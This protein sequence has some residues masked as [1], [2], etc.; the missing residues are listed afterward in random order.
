V[1][2]ITLAGLVV[3]ALSP[4]IAE[5]GK[6]F[7]TQAGDA[8]FE[9]AKRLYDAIHDRFAK[10][11]PKDEGRASKAL[12]TFEKDPDNA[13]TIQTKLARILQDD[14]DFTRELSLIVQSG[15]RQSFTVRRDSRAIDTDMATSDSR[16]LQEI[17]I[18]DNSQIE[19]TRMIIGSGEAQKDR[20]RNRKKK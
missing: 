11:A 10:E 6:E 19:V 2:P 15:P 9:R 13:A 16:S 12:E 18:E 4:Y 17:V 3:T 7:A 20:R 5:I 14:L 8:A 1:D